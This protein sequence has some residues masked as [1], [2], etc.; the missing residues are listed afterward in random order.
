MT[1][2][3]LYGSVRESFEFDWILVEYETI[4]R[5]LVKEIVEV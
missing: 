1:D 2:Y 3:R 4:F 5:V